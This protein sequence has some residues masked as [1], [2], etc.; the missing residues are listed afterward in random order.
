MQPAL[1]LAVTTAAVLG[2]VLATALEHSNNVTEAESNAAWHPSNGDF[3]MLRLSKAKKHPARGHDQLTVPTDM[4]VVD[5]NAEPFGEMPSVEM[6]AAAEK[7]LGFKA[8]R[9]GESLR[10]VKPKSKQTSVSSSNLA[11]TDAGSSTVSQ[12]AHGNGAANEAQNSIDEPVSKALGFL[13]GTKAIGEENK[14]F[15]NTQFAVGPGAGEKRKC[16]G[17]LQS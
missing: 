16:T 3:D 15:E 1:L 7:Q 2:S 6:G 9:E 5:P 17:L 12:E 8:V 11:P 14:P 10:R 13:K 4:A